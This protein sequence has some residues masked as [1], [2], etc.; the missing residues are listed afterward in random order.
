MQSGVGL[1]A[2][3]DVFRQQVRLFY[4][5][6]EK[7]AGLRTESMCIAPHSKIK[8]VWSAYPAGGSYWDFINDLR[9]AWGVNHVIE[10]STIWFLPDDILAMDINYLKSRLSL[11]GVK[12]ASMFGGWTD[13]QLKPSAHQPPPIGFGTAVLD[14][15]FAGLRSRLK[16]AILKLKQALPAIDVLIY[17][18]AQRD[19]SI[20]AAKTFADSLVKDINSQT[21]QTDW[22]GQFS[23]TWSV[24]PTL[25]NHFGSQL[26]GSVL[27]ARSLGADGVYW[28]EMDSLDYSGVRFTTSAWDGHSC[29]LDHRNQILQKIGYTNLLS[30]EAKIEYA[31]MA[32]LVLAN[33]PP[34]TRVFNERPDTHMVEGQHR[35]DYS[36]YIHLS[37]PLAFIGTDVAWSQIIAPLEKGLLPAA[38]RLDYNTPFFAH[39]FPIEVIQISPG[40]VFGREKIIA[41]HSGLY[42]WQTDCNNV[43]I[44]HFDDHGQM[45]GAR[46]GD[47]DPTRP[48]LI[49]ARLA[50]Q[51]VIVISRTSPRQ[52][53]APKT[54]VFFRPAFH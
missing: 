47:R 6:L 43:E 19:S 16:L 48:C 38:V 53:T 25:E 28:D 9:L 18:D 15:R 54:P 5:P 13:P 41:S 34:T 42:G 26:K 24:Y 2:E 27:L 44:L 1:V 51:E 52:S 39:I 17:F 50:P 21:E 40:A 4:D 45:S 31:R 49:N 11:Q 20:G 37:T 8:F 33:S 35:S 14:P 46:Q 3:D 7:K 32:G 10:G 36:S 22:Q 30:S 12:T 23:Q 29:L